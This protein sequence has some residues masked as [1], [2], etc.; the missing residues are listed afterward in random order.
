MTAKATIKATTCG[1]RE[2][3][4]VELV[5]QLTCLVETGKL[6]RAA[7]FIEEHREHAD[8]LGRLLPSI[9][10][11]AS[12]DELSSPGLDLAEGGEVAGDD[13]VPRFAA[14]GDFQILREIGRGGMAVVYEA[15]QL[16]LGRR[17]AVK[18]LPFAAM[19]DER[20]LARFQ[21]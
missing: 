16:S 10:A 4:L 18:V 2:A 5:E 15:E 1:A 17:V 7:A 3:A 12:L 13:S 21:K 14:L 8:V 20:Q 11:L 6:D 9:V 19:L